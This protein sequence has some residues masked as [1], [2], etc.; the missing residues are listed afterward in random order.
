MRKKLK[1]MWRRVRRKENLV[2]G[3]RRPFY[4]PAHRNE[5]PLKLEFSGNLEPLTVRKLFRLVK[6]KRLK[7]VFLMETKSRNK[8]MEV[9]RIK[10]SFANV[11]VVESDE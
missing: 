8:R 4:S 1:D 11:F 3:W 7:M 6:T 2:Q 10:T 5:S 9:V